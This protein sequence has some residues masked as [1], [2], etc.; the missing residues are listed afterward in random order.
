MAPHLQP[1][2][3]LLSDGAE[4]KTKLDLRI[5]PKKEAGGAGLISPCQP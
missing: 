5:A 4:H 1:R 3:K 2:L